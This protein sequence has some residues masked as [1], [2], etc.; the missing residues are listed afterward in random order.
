MTARE[1]DEGIARALEAGADDYLPKPFD[2]DQLLA[3]LRSVLWG[4]PAG[5]WPPFESDGLSIDF[6]AAEVRGGRRGRWG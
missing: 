6:A 2:Q 3:R 1:D 5:A 4:A